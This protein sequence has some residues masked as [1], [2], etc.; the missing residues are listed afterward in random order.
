MK[1]ERQEF[2][3]L[4][5]RRT[6]GECEVRLVMQ[7]YGCGEVSARKILAARPT[8]SELAE[9]R[10]MLDADVVYWNVREGRSLKSPA[11]LIDRRDAERL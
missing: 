2:L 10:G 9:V 4:D 7:V 8:K 6:R 3:R 5:P 1:Y 11:W